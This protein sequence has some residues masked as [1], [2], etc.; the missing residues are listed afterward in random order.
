MTS[1]AHP[2]RS[3]L[4]VL[5]L[6]VVNIGCSVGATAFFA[7]SAHASRPALFVSWQIVGGLFGLMINVTFAGLVRYWSLAAA[8]VIAAGV[9]FVSV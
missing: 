3:A 2:G 8:N 7:A 9:V 5:A 1:S 4:L 6:A